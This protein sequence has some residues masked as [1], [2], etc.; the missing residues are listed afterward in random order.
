MHA[1][2][3]QGLAQKGTVYNQQYTGCCVMLIVNCTFQGRICGAL[4]GLK[5]D[6]AI[7][8]SCHTASF[9]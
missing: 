5:A 3:W 9:Y 1:K 7:A 8:H 6:Q 2:F 4:A